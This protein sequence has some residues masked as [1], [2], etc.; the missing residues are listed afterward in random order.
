[1]FWKHIR[2]WFEYQEVSLQI[3]QKMTYFHTVLSCSFF[4]THLA[5][6]FLS[7]VY[8]R[9]TSIGLGVLQ[10]LSRI[11]I[12]HYYSSLVFLKPKSH[13]SDRISHKVLHGT[14]TIIQSFSK[15]HQRDFSL[16]CSQLD[17]ENCSLERDTVVSV[18][19]A[20]VRLQSSLLCISNAHL[21]L[22]RFEN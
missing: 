7:G 8:Y 21:S 2:A 6:A 18:S 17:T 1:M 5:Q 20:A 4:V 14:E 10:S 3:V 16:L 12:C 22:L 11:S 13:S 9:Q 15:A 19:V